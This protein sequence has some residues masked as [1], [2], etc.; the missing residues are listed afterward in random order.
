MATVGAHII[1][2]D[3]SPAYCRDTTPSSGKSKRNQILKRRLAVSNEQAQAST[4]SR[5][6]A[7]TRSFAH[8]E[9][10]AETKRRVS[11]DEYCSEGNGKRLKDYFDEAE[12]MIRS[13]SSSDGGPPRWFSPLE[14]GP[15]S[16]HSP[17]LLF[18]PGTL[19]RFVI[20][21]NLK[22]VITLI[23]F[24]SNCF[25]ILFSQTRPFFSCPLTCECMKH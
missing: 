22:P 10:E 3:L 7:A 21:L 11:V 5:S 2:A 20:T 17:L 8:N 12:R 18:F 24:L 25:K 4:A 15:H 1:S 16:P 23:T 14:C 9:L 6:T 13:S 19:I